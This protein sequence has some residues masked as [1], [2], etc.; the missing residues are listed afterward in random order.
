M[1]QL[2]IIPCRELNPQP[3]EA[4]VTNCECKMLFCW[5]S[6][7]PFVVLFVDA[8][9]A[10]LDDDVG[11]FREVGEVVPHLPEF[12]LFLL[13]LAFAIRFFLLLLL[14]RYRLQMDWGEICLA[15]WF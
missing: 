15:R 7:H 12:V 6:H 11:D 2:I 8:D 1:K 5:P 3:R 9:C 10:V 4:E 14:C 13:L